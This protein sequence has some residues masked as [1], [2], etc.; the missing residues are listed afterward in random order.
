MKTKF[1]KKLLALFLA[2]VMALTAFSGTLSAFAATADPDYHDDNIT[3]NP[4]GWIELQDE[5]TCAAVLDYID[6]MLAGMDQEIVIYFNATV[7]VINI[8]GRLDSVSGLLDIVDQFD[9]LIDDN[10]SVLGMAGDLG[11]VDLSALGDLPYNSNYNESQC[12]KAYRERN[13]AKEILTALFKTLYGL[14]GPVQAIRF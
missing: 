9:Q 14:A 8:Q 1:S 2:V 12:G 11:S 3:A 5:Q 10:G 4:L 13:S 7:L 6:Q